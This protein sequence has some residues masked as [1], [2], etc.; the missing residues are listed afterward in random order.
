MPQPVLDRV[1]AHLGLEMQVGGYVAADAV[2]DEI[3]AVYALLA[4]FVNGAVSE[5]ALVENATVAWQMAF[6]S[7]PF[8][9]GDRLLTAKAAYAS[10][11]ISYLQLAQKQGVSIEVIPDDAQGQVDVGALRKMMD[12]RVRLIA[13]THVPTNGG[14]VNPAA[15]VGRVAREWDTL[16][17]LDA[18]QSVGQMPIDVG[19]IGCD[20]LSAT[21][22]KWLRGPRGTGF[23]VVRQGVLD[24]LEPPFLDL[25]G[26]TWVARDRYEMRPDARRFENWEKAWANVLGM[27]TAVSYANSFGMDNIWARVQQLATSLRQQLRQIPGVTV[28]DKGAVQGG[29]VTFTI[30]GVNLK[31]VQ[32]YLRQQQINVTT[33]TTF[34]TRLDMEDRQLTEVLRASIHYF[35][36][37]EEIGRFCKA[38]GDFLTQRRKGAK[39]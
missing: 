30:E 32:Q 15:A 8:Q 12:E 1:L 31:A 9:A 19:A 35:N 16:Y 37:D 33:S 6:H 3:E 2:K 17:L 25:R 5:I 7:I 10:N 29:I 38:I 27:A 28:R 18:C 20:L 26:A 21:G 22:R 39:E 13:I 24:K 4:G 11:Y 23:L 14:L 36:T 34:S